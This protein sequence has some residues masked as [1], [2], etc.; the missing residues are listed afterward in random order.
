MKTAIRVFVILGAMIAAIFGSAGRWNLPFA[1]ASLGIAV[2][3]AAT[4]IFKID[5]SLRRERLN[6]A[7]GGQDRRLRATMVPFM[8]GGWI[9][10]GLDVGRFHWSD[11]IP[12]GWRV[13]GLVGLALGIGISFWAMMANRFFSP[14]VRIQQERGHHLITSGPYQ[15]LRHPGYLG[16]IASYVSGTMALGSWWALL[17]AAGI[18]VLIVRRTRLEDRFL[19]HELEGYA[20]YAEKVR[21]GLLPGVW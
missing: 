4:I 10:A 21:Y 9:V 6:P 5:P 7:P 11:T 18:T 12:F 19:Q 17:P 13:A 20:A 8:L 2:A 1:W 3:F 15:Y 16:T 14:V